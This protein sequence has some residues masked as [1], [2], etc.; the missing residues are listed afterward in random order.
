ME[1]ID[2]IRVLRRRWLLVVL[3]VLVSAGAA[4]AYSVR[5]PPV[6]VAQT[7]AVVSHDAA[8]NASTAD[9]TGAAQDA[10]TATT[11]SQ[12]GGSTPVLQ[13]ALQQA[14]ISIRSGP[15]SIS[16]VSTPASPFL[17]VRATADD[18]VVATRLANAVPLVLPDVITRL[19]EARPGSFVL[20]VVDTAGPATKTQPRPLRA[21]GLGLVLGLLLGCGAAG[22]RESLDRTF[23]DPDKLENV[24]RRTVLGAVPQELA[25]ETLPSITYPGSGRSEAYRQVMTNIQFAGPQHSLKAIVVTSATAGEGKTTTSVN[26]AVAFARTGQTVV[27]VDADLRRPKVAAAFSL[28]ASAGLTGVLGGLLPLSQAIVRVDDNRV[29]VLPAGPLPGNPSELLGSSAMQDVMDELSARFDVVI[30]DS[31]PVLP[32]ADPLILAVKSTALIVVVRLGSTTRERVKRTLANIDKVNVPLLGIVANGAVA[33]DDAAYGYGYG[34]YSKRGGKLKDM[35]A[36]V[37]LDPERA[38]PRPDPES[39]GFERNRAQGALPKGSTGSTSAMGQAVEVS[40]AEAFR[41]TIIDGQA[42]TSYMADQQPF[43]PTVKAS[44]AQPDEQ[45]QGAAGD[46]WP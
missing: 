15:V 18:A 20:R 17:T 46:V 4:V 43:G 12:I 3:A 13:A 11:L 22:L 45:R 39:G 37:Q 16:I 23:G 5:Q 34:Y 14:G 24:T 36:D 2:Y 42:R 19:L 10:L 35:P 41:P 27:I 6:Y 40:A 26:L 38:N 21:G 32:V 8:K 44:G 7:N 28:P 30:V 9:L 29:A 33:R 31:P 1:L 25:S